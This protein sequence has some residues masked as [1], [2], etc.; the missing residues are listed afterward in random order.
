AVRDSGLGRG[1]RERS[2]R[3]S[4]LFAGPGA[5][6]F[7]LEAV[8]G[9]GGAAGVA[10]ATPPP[11]SGRVSACGQRRGVPRGRRHAGC[12]AVC[13]VSRAGGGALEEPL[14]PKG[15]RM[16]GAEAVRAVLHL[17]EG[18]GSLHRAGFTD[19]ALGADRVLVDPRGPLLI[20]L[21]GLRAA[22]WRRR[23]ANPERV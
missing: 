22:L 20:E 21:P 11:D 6:P 19:G 18:F 7:V 4:C 10:G 16:G 23:E 1:E 2:L 15:G 13:R 9:R 14:E 17:R 8:S 5:G 3:P 12:R